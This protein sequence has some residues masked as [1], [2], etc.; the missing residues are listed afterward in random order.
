MELNLIRE[1]NATLRAEVAELREDKARID[2]LLSQGLCWRDCDKEIPGEYWVVG[3]RTEWL[4]RA[5]G[6]RDRID[7]ARKG[8]P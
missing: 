7:A 4:Y 5:G 1:E 3:E 2:W 8:Q 6:G